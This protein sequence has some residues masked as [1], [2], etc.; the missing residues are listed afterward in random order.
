MIEGAMSPSRRALLAAVPAGPPAA[1]MLY[2]LAVVP[3][4]GRLRLPSPGYGS[5]SR[6]HSV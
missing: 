1:I 2:S 6:G 5:H 3:A 4:D